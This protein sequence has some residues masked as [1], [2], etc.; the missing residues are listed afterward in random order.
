[1]IFKYFSNPW[2]LIHSLIR[3]SGCTKRNCCHQGQLVSWIFV[4]FFYAFSG[5]RPQGA[6]DLVPDGSARAWVILKYTFILAPVRL[7]LLL[8]AV[9]IPSGLALVLQMLLKIVI[10]TTYIRTNYAMWIQLYCAPGFHHSGYCPQKPLDTCESYPCMWG[11]E[12]TQN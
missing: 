4:E 12:I 10:N 2:F 1:M 11:S 3:T 6:S 8:L 7:Q 9:L 5:H